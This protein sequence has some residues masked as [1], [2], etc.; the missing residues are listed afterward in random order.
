MISGSEGR[1][2]YISIPTRNILERSQIKMII[3][4]TKIRME[5]TISIIGGLAIFILPN[6]MIGAKKGIMDIVVIN[7]LSGDFTMNP[8]SMSGTTKNMMIGNM[9]CCASWSEFVMAPIAEKRAE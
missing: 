3:E 2:P 5:P 1:L 7:V 8:M 6:I 4:I 9:S